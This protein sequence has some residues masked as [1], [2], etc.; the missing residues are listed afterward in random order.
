MSFEIEEEVPDWVIDNLRESLQTEEKFIEKEHE[1]HYKLQSLATLIEHLNQNIAEDSATYELLKEVEHSIWSIEEYIQEENL[2]EITFIKEEKE[3]IEAV[4]EELTHKNYQAVHKGVD[5]EYV[6]LEEHSRT[7]KHHLKELHNR[8]LTLTK[9][10]KRKKINEVFEK[11]KIDKN[12]NYKK[13]KQYFIEIH[14]FS[15]IYQHILWHLWKKEHHLLKNV[16][17]EMK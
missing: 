7:E 14:K 3:K 10:S 4:E 17:K 11:D 15:R 1:L 16:K 13:I 5:E 12:K 6:P 8:F 9:E 2:H